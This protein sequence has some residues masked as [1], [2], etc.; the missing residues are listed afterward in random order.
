MRDNAEESI[1]SGSNVF[2]SLFII[3]A[4]F[5]L[6]SAAVLMIRQ[7][8][9]D[10]V[11]TGTTIDESRY[12]DYDGA[13]V[14]GTQV[15]S[16]IKYFA[17]DEICITV[18]NG[19]ATTSYIYDS[20]DLTSNTNVGQIAAAQTKSNINAYINPSSKYVGEIVRDAAGGTKG[21]IVGIN[22]NVQ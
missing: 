14:T 1:K 10:L 12:T 6:V 22:F 15:V 9:D 8:T 20:T 19:H 13:L 3:A 18:N 21:T 16:A 17:N 11:S 2:I 4:V 7:G 5:A